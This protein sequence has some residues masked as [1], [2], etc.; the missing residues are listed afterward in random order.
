[1]QY[2]TEKHWV[3]Q[4]YDPALRKLSDFCGCRLTDDRG[5][6]WGCDTTLKLLTK[7]LTSIAQR[8]HPNSHSQSIFKIHSIREALSVNAIHKETQGKVALNLYKVF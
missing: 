4:F 3:D 2:N 5:M 8:F 1:M 6:G 7:L